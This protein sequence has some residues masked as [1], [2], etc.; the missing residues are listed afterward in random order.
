MVATIRGGSREESAAG[1]A[2]SRSRALVRSLP[3]PFRFMMAGG[4]GLA[5]D[6]ALFT[7]MLM[8]G[9]HPLLAGFVF[10]GPALV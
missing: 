7:L 8:E 1:G 10:I 5:A 6:L 2:L 9:V 4:L 3:R